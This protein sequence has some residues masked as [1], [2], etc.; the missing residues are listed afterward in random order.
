MKKIILSAILFYGFFLFTLGVNA[1]TSL[2]VGERKDIFS[3]ENCQVVNCVSSSSALEVSYNLDL[4]RGVGKEIGEATVT[5]TCSNQETREFKV[6]VLDP[7]R[8][9]QPMYENVADAQNVNCD[10]L[11]LLRKDLNG[12]FN[13]AKI[14]IPI[15][16]IVMSTYDF[17]RAITGKVEGDTKKAFQKFLKRLVFAVLF[18][19]LPNILDFFLGLIDPSYTTCINS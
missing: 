18:F 16:I 13:V 17:I 9:T 1:D 2:K 7:N 14:V 10:S 11:G 4:C 12:I 15:L 8:E 5:V 19:F 6:N 3:E